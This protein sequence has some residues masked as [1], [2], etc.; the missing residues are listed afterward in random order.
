MNQAR[1]EFARWDAGQ[2]LLAKYLRQN[3]QAWK[4]NTE[5]SLPQSVLDAFKGFCYETLEP[6]FIAEMLTLP[7]QNEVAG[8]FKP[9]DVDA[10]AES[11]SFIKRSIAAE[12][13]DEL[14]AIYHS[15]KQEQYTVE[16]AAIGQRSLRNVCLSYLAVTDEGESLVVAQYDTANNM[17]DTMAAMSAAN[18][19]QLACRETLMKDFSDKW[20]HDGLVMDK[21]F[22]LQGT[23]P[24]QNA[25]TVIKETMSHPAFSLKIQTVHAV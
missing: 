7:S 13:V 23:N 3:I 22:M 20:S 10:I 9:V 17:T 12:L 19:A 5:L 1:N 25:L 21:W 15:L 18:Q 14:T 11:L 2:T 16:H 6:A 24:A 8:W 4:T